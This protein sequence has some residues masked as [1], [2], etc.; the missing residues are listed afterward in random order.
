MVIVLDLATLGDGRVYGR[1]PV[2]EVGKYSWSVRVAR[3]S[4]PRT[5]IPLVHL[6]KGYYA[7]DLLATR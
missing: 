2:V 7:C 4:G 5:D 1:L 6:D 3:W